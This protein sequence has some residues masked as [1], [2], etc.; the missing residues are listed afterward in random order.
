MTSATLD[1]AFSALADPTRRAILARLTIGDAT[2]TELAEP[3]DM[4]QPAI[5]KHVKVLEQAGL[6]SRSRD[7]QK[8]PVHLEAA[9]LA[10]ATGW[11]D[12][13]RRFWEQRFDKLDTVLDEMKADETPPK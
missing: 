4:T 9:P 12:A 1:A 10:A 11:L 8:R 13:Y 3:F 2:I 6:V 7:A 5:S